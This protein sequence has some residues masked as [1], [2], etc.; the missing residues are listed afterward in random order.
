MRKVVA[1]GSGLDR[2]FRAVEYPTRGRVDVVERDGENSLAVNERM[3]IAANGEW[4]WTG[5]ARHE[6]DRRRPD[7]G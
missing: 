7:G 4:R 3:A 1:P 5:V 2:V 6:D